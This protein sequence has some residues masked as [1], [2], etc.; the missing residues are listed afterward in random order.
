MC[1]KSIFHAVLLRIVVR[2][3]LKEDYGCR[4]IEDWINVRYCFVPRFI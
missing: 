4:F 3:L 2:G 1:L